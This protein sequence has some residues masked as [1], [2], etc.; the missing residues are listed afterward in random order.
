MANGPQEIKI[1]ASCID[2]TDTDRV[3]LLVLNLNIPQHVVQEEQR[4]NEILRGA[5]NFFQAHFAR[6]E[7][8]FQ[9]NASYTLWNR[10]TGQV[11][12]WTGSFFPGANCP[13]SLSGPVF[14][15]FERDAFP[16]AVKYCSSEN[17][18]SDT[19][20]IGIEDSKWSFLALKSII[21][22]FQTRV[23]SGHPF[24]LHYGMQNPSR[25]RRQRHVVIRW[26]W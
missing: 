6:D 4:F 5:A 9:V 21:V 16:A 15:T 3:K 17:R 24:L 12:L 23:S 19:Y 22:N 25:G 7:L 26:P 14:V 8:V 20:E 11:R 13:L 2:Y 10:S 1:D 18:I